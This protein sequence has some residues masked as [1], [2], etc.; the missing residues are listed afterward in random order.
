MRAHYIGGY[1]LGVGKK[2][3]KHEELQPQDGTARGAA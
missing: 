3:G 2:Q 1:A